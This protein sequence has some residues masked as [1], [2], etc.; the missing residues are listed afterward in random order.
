VTGTER[1]AIG[2]SRGR[3]A[4]AR[5]VECTGLGAATIAIVLAPGAAATSSRIAPALTSAQVSA[6]QTKTPRSPELPPVAWAR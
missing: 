2:L 4:G 3:S 1:I 5:P 6:S